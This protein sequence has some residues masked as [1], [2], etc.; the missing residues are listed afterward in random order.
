MEYPIYEL[1]VCLT[2]FRLKGTYRDKEH[3]CQCMD[4]DDGWRKG[5]WDGYDIPA[6]IDL[7]HVCLRDTVASGSRWSWYACETCREINVSAGETIG[8][9]K[10]GALRWGVI[11]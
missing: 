11:R 2:C 8:V 10:W 5:E 9:E 7:C 1:A 4:R 6:F 3:R